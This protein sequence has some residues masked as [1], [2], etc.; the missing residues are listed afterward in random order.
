MEYTPKERLARLWAMAERD[1]DCQALRE[2][3]E[4]ARRKLEERTDRMSKEESLV[5]WELPTCTHTFFGRILE[6]AARE[7]RFPGEP[8]A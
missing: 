5:R 7:M 4:E 8:E 1:P 6:L 3:M 2:E